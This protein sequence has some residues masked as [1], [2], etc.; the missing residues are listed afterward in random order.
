MPSPSTL[1]RSTQDA[2]TEKLTPAAASTMQ[3]SS[4]RISGSLVGSQEAD[5]M[6]ST[7]YAPAVA[8]RRRSQEWQYA[9]SMW[10]N[11]SDCR[12]VMR[13]H[14]LHEPKQRVFLQAAQTRVLDSAG[15][16]HTCWQSG[17]LLH[18]LS[19]GA[20]AKSIHG[21]QTGAPHCLQGLLSK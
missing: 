21:P 12:W 20:S 17:Q 3:P 18:T 11:L 6:A 15:V 5:V 14:R 4:Q 2:P 10:L 19:G 7:K 16:K 9:Q 1:K 8:G 13:P